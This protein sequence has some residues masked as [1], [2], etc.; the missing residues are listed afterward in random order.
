MTK[1]RIK[2]NLTIHM[3]TSMPDC[4]TSMLGEEEGLYKLGQAGELELVGQRGRK[5]GRERYCLDRSGARLCQEEDQEE[6]RSDNCQQQ[7]KY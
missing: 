5:V 4:K 6:D 1:T 2:T 3:M 7:H